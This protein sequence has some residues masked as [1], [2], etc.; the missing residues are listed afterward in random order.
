MAAAAVLLMLRG[1]NSVVQYCFMVTES[2]TQQ[3]CYCCI[4]C[5]AATL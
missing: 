1:L 4:N 5:H 3:Q 2:L